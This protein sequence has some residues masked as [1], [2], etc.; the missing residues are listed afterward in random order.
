MTF[1]APSDNLAFHWKCI[2]APFT[3][4]GYIVLHELCHMLHR[5]HTDVFWN[6]VDK[7]MP[8]YRKRKKWLRKN[9]VGL[10][11]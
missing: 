7:I 8:S 4:I 11:V 6:E 3:I 1:A 10:D 2:M 9:G 5:D